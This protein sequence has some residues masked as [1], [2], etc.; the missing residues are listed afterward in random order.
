MYVCCDCNTLFT[1]DPR[2]LCCGAGRLRDVT[3]HSLMSRVERQ[4]NRI[5]RL[6]EQVIKAVRYLEQAAYFEEADEIYSIIKYY[7]F[8]RLN[9]DA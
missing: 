7:N 2:C 5:V 3:V 8:K 4:H 1:S 6:E 9:G